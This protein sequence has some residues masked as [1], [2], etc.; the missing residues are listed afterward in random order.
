MDEQ[1]KPKKKI[2]CLA[3]GGIIIGAFILIV[4]IAAIASGGKN[5]GITKNT[6]NTGN[7]TQNTTAAQNGT[8]NTT[9]TEAQNTGKPQIEFTNVNFQNQ[10]GMTTV[11]GEAKNNDSKAHSFTLTVSF[12]DN[13]KKLLGSASGA[14]V[15]SMHIFASPTAFCFIR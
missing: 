4:I 15:L 9:L 6:T 2:G 11:I 5:G 12:Y 3:I 8:Q 13:N 10:V 14:M 7:V 1:I